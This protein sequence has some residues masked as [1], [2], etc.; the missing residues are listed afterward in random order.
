MTG[1]ALQV[2]SSV[3][4]RWLT[5]TDILCVALSW[6]FCFDHAICEIKESSPYQSGFAISDPGTTT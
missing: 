6:A 4:R 1:I 3:I 2:V 5:G